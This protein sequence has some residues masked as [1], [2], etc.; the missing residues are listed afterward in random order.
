MFH[1]R[2][3]VLAPLVALAGLWVYAVASELVGLPQFDLLVANRANALLGHSRT[4]DL[5]MVFLLEEPGDFFGTLLMVLL[6]M[7]AYRRHRGS[8]VNPGGHLALALLFMLVLG[9]AYQLV[10]N[11]LLDTILRTS[12]NQR[13]ASF[14]QVQELYGMSIDLTHENSFPL[15][16]AAYFFTAFF[17]NMFLFGRRLIVPTALVALACSGA[18]VLAGSAWLSDLLVGLLLGWLLAALVA[19]TPLASFFWS[20]ERFLHDF[21]R[22][23]IGRH[24]LRRLASLLGR[25]SGRWRALRRRR[26]APVAAL[27]SPLEALLHSAWGIDQVETLAPPHKGRVYKIRADGRVLA[28]KISRL[29]ADQRPHLDRLLEVIQ[30]CRERAG[31]PLPAYLPTLAGEWSAEGEDGRLVSLIEWVEGHPP[32]L[33]QPA[34]MRVLMRLLARLHLATEPEVA[35]PADFV[36]GH[37]DPVLHAANPTA[38]MPEFL[39][40]EVLRALAMAQLANN[41]R[42]EDDHPA[43]PC[44]IHGD[45]HG[46]N[47]IIDK[48]DR[49][50]LIDYDRMRPG[51]AYEDLERP[52]R[53]LMLY[54]RWDFETFAGVLE[55]YLA[56][57][58]LP[59]YEIVMLLARIVYPRRGSKL[60]SKRREREPGQGGWARL[61]R[62]GLF[63]SAQTGARMNFIRK[64]ARHYQVPLVSLCGQARL[65]DLPSPEE[66]DRPADHVL[67]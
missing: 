5:T 3:A 8:Q 14:V 4:F 1:P 21:Y 19:R 39:R 25:L 61:L 67:S 62:H 7:Q 47:Y 35:V 23:R 33:F 15:D 57:R 59:R 60:I 26:P 24:A 64:A 22:I 6:V 30:A 16:R 37:K 11:M 66:A 40:V 41:Y 63:S 56:A 52:L 10:D 36:R 12:P 2:W 46:W 20:S 38:T 45:T 48:D 32:D 31:L 53:Q 51:L 65:E 43:T 13:I 42:L 49:L 29:M 17:L 9:V 55:A 50:S 58:P 54:Y 34:Q 27:P 28:L 44:W 18:H